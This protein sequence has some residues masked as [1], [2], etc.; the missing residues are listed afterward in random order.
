MAH[1]RRNRT[2]ARE[3][4]AGGVHRLSAKNGQQCLTRA[5]LRLDEQQ[6][7]VATYVEDAGEA[8]AHRGE[9][10]RVDPPRLDRAGDKRLLAEEHRQR[11]EV[12]GN[13]C[14]GL[15]R[16]SPSVRLR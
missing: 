1:L 13:A 8:S 6:Q 2:L 12:G 10:L 4:T 3:G 11:G 9:R 16:T 5:A 15:A 14:R 7:R